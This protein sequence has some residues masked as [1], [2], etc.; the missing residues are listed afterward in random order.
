MLIQKPTQAIRYDIDPHFVARFQCLR[1][2]MAE[3]SQFAASV[4]CSCDGPGT[5]S[6]LAVIQS[7]NGSY[8]AAC[9]LVYRYFTSVFVIEKT[10]CIILCTS[11]SSIFISSVALLNSNSG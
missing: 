7:A 10:I 6:R 2:V 1:A 4:T 5:A 11:D 3:D 8:G 9:S